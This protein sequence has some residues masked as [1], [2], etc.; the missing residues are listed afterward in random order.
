MENY[1]KSIKIRTILS[2]FILI[3]IKDNLYYRKR[4]LHGGYQVL[5]VNPELVDVDPELKYELVETFDTK[6]DLQNYIENL[7]KSI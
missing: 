7:T 2:I 5:E 6:Q 3:P 4:L 1:S